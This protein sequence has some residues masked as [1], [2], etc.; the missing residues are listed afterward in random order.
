MSERMGTLRQRLRDCIIDQSHHRTMAEVFSGRRAE[1]EANL[2]EE[3]YGVKVG[4]IVEWDDNCHCYP[5]GPGPKRQRTLV[6]DIDATG[7]EAGAPIEITGRNWA[8]SGRW[9]RTFRR[10]KSD[11]VV[12]DA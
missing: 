9:A 3:L 10:V 8:R 4:S 7:I 5:G 2:A 1:L 12:V 11:F 6:T